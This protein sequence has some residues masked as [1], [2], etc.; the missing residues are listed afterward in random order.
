M[1]QMRWGYW[2][3]SLLIPS[4]LNAAE[5]SRK[6]DFLREVRPIL[7]DNCFTCHGPDE[8]TRM[9][10]VRLDTREGAFAAGPSGP[11]IVPGNPDASRIVARVAHE[12]EPLRMPPPAAGPRL[13]E[14]QVE[15]IRRWI[16]QGA[17]WS[18]HWAYVPPARPEP[19]SVRQPGWPRNPID[20][21][22]LARLEKEG[23]KPS[24]EADRR[25][26]IRRLTLDLTGLPPTPAEVEAF[27]RDRSPDAYE[28]LVDRL[29]ASPHYGERMAMQWLDL[30][31]YADSHGFH[32]DSHRDM[33]RWRDWVIDAFNRNMPYDRFA[34]EQLAGDLL[35]S[36][37]V[38]QRLATGFNRNHMINFEGG[39][40]PEEYHVEYVVDRVETTATAFLAMTMGCARCH[41]HKYDPIKQKEFYQFAAFFNNIDEKGLDGQRGNAAPLLA[42][43]TPE[44]AERKAETERLIPELEKQ[45]ESPEIQAAY[46]AWQQTAADSL[47][48]PTR[49]GLV[50][51][52]EFD[53]SLADTSGRYQHGRSL[54]DDPAFPASPSGGQ[55]VD[56]SGRSEVE[57][58][59][60]PLP[61]TVTFWF[62]TGARTG[63]TG[64]LARMDS[65]GR[66]WEIFL[67]E[68][69][70]IPRLRQRAAF[71]IRKV[72][73]WPDRVWEARTKHP[74]VVRG[75]RG[76]DLGWF[77]VAIAGETFYL[78]GRPV[79]LE[80]TRNTLSQPFE[81]V[82]GPVTIGG[83]READRLRGRLD[84]LRFY[85]RVLTAGEIETIRTSAPLLAHLT[86]PAAK[87]AKEH[88]AALRQWY[89]RHAAPEETRAL[90]ARLEQ[91]KN[92]AED[93][94][95]EIPTVMVM[96]ELETPRDAF[97]LARGD[98][99]NPTEKVSPAVPAFLPPLPDEAPRNRLGLAQWLVSPD[100]PLTSRVAVNRFWQIY[101]HTGLVKTAEDFGS[102]GEPPSHPELLD[103][104]AAEFVRTGWD[105][106]AMQ[107]LIVTSA[108][109]RQVSRSTPALNERDPENRLLARGPRFRLPAEIVRDTALAV[110]G[111]LVPEVGGPPVLPYQPPGIWEELA[112]GA[113]F[114]A[115]VYQQ[116]HG[117]DLYRRSM[118]TFW[119]RTAPPAALATFDAPD[120]E[121][122]IARRPLTNTPL[123]ALVLLN[124][125]TYVEAAR[126]LAARILREAKGSRRVEHG[127]LLATGRRPNRQE[128][129]LLSGLARQQ[130]AA[131]R[132]NPKMAKL[133]LSVGESEPA[134]GFD[135]V[136][137]AAWTMV[138]STILNLD[139]TITKE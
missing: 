37:T 113:E 3:L 85:D 68:P 128:S 91:L 131:Y 41:D 60:L 38:E 5:P 70:A 105:V 55:A 121:K 31:R 24:P 42:L 52:Y 40:I 30:A 1:K 46:E 115:Q 57:L 118:Y 58:A 67:D 49:Q 117:K 125:P 126:A 83:R 75:Y 13:N 48:Q 28:K 80:I 108:T 106:K 94:E 51:H 130:L 82:D 76:A 109:Y 17:E 123:Q 114:S 88:E 81:E 138:A 20:N 73:R 16:E 44:Q 107:R 61:K 102:Q 122:C 59:A 87:R 6:V 103:W 63:K 129:S 4:S 134:P 71:V 101:F 32:I 54:R 43:P 132:S 9:A 39:A 53:G 50:A 27:V 22:I 133:L 29:L 21:F 11:L 33:W 135:P 136:E 47:P 77:H 65:E 10:G 116:S 93:L 90:Y 62:R 110:G 26:L 8:G 69:F 137:L 45:I 14:K 89:L 79:E 66:G 95:W 96:Q 100:H 111:L 97:V 86:L 2:I 99:R 74:P 34:V 15:L 92:E 127:F 124:D 139:E 84:D 72:E 120:R 119:K 25:T 78:N 35:P 12:K 7:S 23:L 36:P 104:L 18:T 64:I 56:M 19:P 98:Y 112:F